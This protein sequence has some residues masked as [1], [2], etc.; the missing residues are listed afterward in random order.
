[1][2]KRSSR[3]LHPVEKADLA[4]AETVRV[5]PQSAEAK[6]LGQFAELGDQP[7]LIAAC[8]GVLAVGLG[9]GDARM[10]RTAL[11]MLAAHGFATAAKSMVKDRIDRTRPGVA[12][13]G[14]YKL[15]EGASKAGGMRSMPSGHSAGLAAVAAAVA[16]EYPEAALPVGAAAA[17][18]AAAQLPSENHF[19]SDVAV[20]IAIGLAAESAVGLLLKAAA[21]ADAKD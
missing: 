12:R 8:A 5:G 10:V 2:A 15:K 4:T 14:N 11:H 9:R 13:K 1:M 19:L 16:R 17:S 3:K 7:P 20:G 18:V 6:L 21:A